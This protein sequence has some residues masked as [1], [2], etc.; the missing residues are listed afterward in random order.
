[1]LSF[2]NLK[3]IRYVTLN[4]LRKT[5]V[6]Q[7]ADCLD[8]FRVSNKATL[9]IDITLR[10][11]YTTLHYTTSGQEP[12]ALAWHPEQPACHQEPAVWAQQ[13]QQQQQA[14]PRPVPLASAEQ[15]A[16]EQ[17]ALAPQALAPLA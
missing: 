3:S 15:L 7:Q 16:L 5:Q 17:L 9:F 8:C 13:Q 14:L 4:S 6:N 2:C 10:H 12:A 11:H 1:M